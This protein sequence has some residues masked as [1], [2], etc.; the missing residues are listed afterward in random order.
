[1]FADVSTMLNSL[2]LVRVA[3]LASV[4]NVRGES[5]SLIV[6]F[7]LPRYCEQGLIERLEELVLSIFI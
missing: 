1:M 6:L 2:R 4:L 7:D 5:N 3:T